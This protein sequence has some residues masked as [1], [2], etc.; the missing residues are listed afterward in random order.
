MAISS[1]P[2]PYWQVSLS[3]PLNLGFNQ[4]DYVTAVRA[5]VSQGLAGIWSCGCGKCFWWVCAFFYWNHMLVARTKPRHRLKGPA[6]D[7]P[8]H[9]CHGEAKG[10]PVYS[11]VSHVQFWESK[12]S[13]EG[14]LC[15]PVELSFFSIQVLNLSQIERFAHLTWI[16]WYLVI[17]PRWDGTMQFSVSLT[18][19]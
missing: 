5:A 16:C 14:A 3:P 18:I 2:Y 8:R 10:E 11:P 6:A 13:L 1:I 17:C 12:W 4:G 9:G 15:P 19:K 7:P